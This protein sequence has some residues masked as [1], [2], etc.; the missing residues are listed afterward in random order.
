MS[1]TSVNGGGGTGHTAATVT[2][3]TSLT[4]ANSGMIS[5]TAGTVTGTTS[6][7]LASSGTISQ[8]GGIVVQRRC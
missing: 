7:T 6:L 4:L 2:G 1:I 3:T 5:Q 8:T